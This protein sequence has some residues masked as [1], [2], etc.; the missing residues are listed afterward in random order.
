VRSKYPSYPP[1]ASA[2][3]AAW[4]MRS[5]TVVLRHAALTADL[6][7]TLTKSAHFAIEGGFCT[8]EYER[9]V[10]EETWHKCVTELARGAH[11]RPVTDSQRVQGPMGF[12]AF[13]TRILARHPID[14]CL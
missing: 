14:E 4:A 5:A 10:E 13:V 9:A 7:V 6:A 1:S 2:W 3:S 11:R 12:A 8:H